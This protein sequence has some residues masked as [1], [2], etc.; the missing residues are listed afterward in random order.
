MHA[1]SIYCILYINRDHRGLNFDTVYLRS[2]FS[3][4]SNHVVR[5]NI[6]SVKIEILRRFLIR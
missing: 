5:K 2:T 3:L 4:F 1:I 6:Y